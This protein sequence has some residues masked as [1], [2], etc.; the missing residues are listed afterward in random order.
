MYVWI[1]IAGVVLVLIVAV[2]RSPPMQDFLEAWRDRR[3][4]RQA[5]REFEAYEKQYL[6]DHPPEPAK[7]LRL[8]DFLVDRDP[9]DDE[10]YSEWLIVQHLNRWQRTVIYLHARI[11][12]HLR[13]EFSEV[14]PG[15][16][17]YGHSE[18]DFARWRNATWC[19]A[20]YLYV[21][22]ANEQY[23]GYLTKNSSRNDLNQVADFIIAR[24]GHVYTGRN[25]IDYFNDARLSTK[26]AHAIQKA[27]ADTLMAAS[28]H[29][30][31]KPVAEMLER[32]T[33]GRHWI[34]EHWPYPQAV[35]RYPSVEQERD[36]IALAREAIARCRDDQL[37]P[38]EKTPAR[39]IVLGYLK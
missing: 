9:P 24:D 39:S 23:P 19:Y 22:V 10:A 2:A 30:G 16:L 33:P 28:S 6:I 1:A 11:M 5:D 17:Y 32:G 14:V 31:T 13:A 3:R 18:K 27:L 38:D 37:S 29:L 12:A 20:Y 21:L 4:K 34:G 7:V 15:T 25:Y 35:C 26:N 8:P 36:L